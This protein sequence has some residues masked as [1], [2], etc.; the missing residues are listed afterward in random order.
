MRRGRDLT[1]GKLTIKHVHLITSLDVLD[2]APRP[3]RSLGQ[4]PL[5]YQNLLHH[6]RDRTFRE[7]DSKVRTGHLP[8]TMASLRNL[9][10]SV[11]RQD[12]ETNIAPLLRL[13]SWYPWL[14]FVSYPLRPGSVMET[15]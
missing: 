11:F 1:T 10:T 13:R 2:A 7:D 3:A 8:G 14:I 9:A 15:R 6:V 12:G 5:G 4:R